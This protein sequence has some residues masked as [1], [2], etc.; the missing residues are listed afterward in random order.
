MSSDILSREPA[1][2][3]PLSLSRTGGFGRFVGK[4]GGW[5]VDVVYYKLVVTIVAGALLLAKNKELINTYMPLLTPFLSPALT[6]LPFWESRGD[7][8]NI[9]SDGNMT[10]YG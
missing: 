6:F 5:G 3:P 9:M 7:G 2:Y 8:Y 10:S 4:R 1:S